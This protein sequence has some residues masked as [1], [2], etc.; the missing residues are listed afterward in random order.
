MND[1]ERKVILKFLMFYE[2]LESNERE[3]F[4]R[5]LGSIIK[6]IIKDGF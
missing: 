2:A 5:V 3:I 4:E 1:I 6:N